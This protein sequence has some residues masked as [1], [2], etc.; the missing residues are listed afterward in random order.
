PKTR[1]PPPAAGE[2]LE[3]RLERPRIWLLRVWA[4]AVLG[5]KEKEAEPQPRELAPPRSVQMPERPRPVQRLPEA[6]PPEPV[7]E[8]AKRPP[9]LGLDLDRPPPAHA[10]GDDQLDIPAFLR[11]QAN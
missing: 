3:H 5:R 1:R 9:T 7:S 4:W 11:R 2:P 10:P 6:P 8:F